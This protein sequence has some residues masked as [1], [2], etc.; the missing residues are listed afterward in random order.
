MRIAR[1]VV[2]AVVFQWVCSSFAFSALIDREKFESNRKK[3]LEVVSD[4]VSR[5]GKASA[6]S[7]FA[8]PYD[9]NGD[10]M[11]DAQE[12]TAIRDYLGQK[13][14]PPVQ[15]VSEKKEPV[16]TM[17]SFGREV[18]APVRTAEKDITTAV[19]K[20]TKKRSWY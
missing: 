18:T 3:A 2:V 7:V 1:M 4:E 20:E 8:K 12:L 15:A 9:T 13:S 19:K 16:K 14:A 11:I 17:E 5:T 6:G 10:G